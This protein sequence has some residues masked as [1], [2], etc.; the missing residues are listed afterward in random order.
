M[1]KE[2]AYIQRVL[3]KFPYI[4]WDRFHF[5]KS[6]N[7][8]TIYGWIDR[9][10][11]YYKDFVCFNFFIKPHFRALGVEFVSTSSARYSKRIAKTLSIFSKHYDCKRAEDFFNVPNLI[12]LG[13]DEDDY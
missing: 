8:L 4:K 1:N 2:I 9:E 13:D 5:D 10:K 6:Q 11:D 12:K 7:V 3:R